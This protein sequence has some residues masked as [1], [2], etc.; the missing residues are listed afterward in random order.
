MGDFVWE[1]GTDA[2]TVSDGMARI[3]GVPAGEPLP[4]V[5]YFM[6][7]AGDERSEV[8]RR[9]RRAV[10]A[11]RPID[12]DV[13][14][15]RPDG[16]RVT[17]NVRGEVV[18]DADGRPERVTGTVQDVTARRAAE[19]AM[20]AK[21]QAERANR[22]KSEFLSRMSHELRTPLN[23]ILGFGQLLE[24]DELGPD[25]EDSVAHIMRAGHH[26]LELID[27][28]LDLSRIEAGALRLMLEPVDVGSVVEEILG[29]AAP[30]AT[31]EAIELTADVPHDLHVRADR[32]RLRQVLLNLVSNAIKYNR[33]A[34]RVRVSV[35]AHGELGRIAVED[36]GLGIAADD[37][38]KLF[39]PFERLGAEAS[40]VRGTGL[41]LAVSR[42][43]CDGMGGVLAA[44][45]TVGEG[46]TFAVDL[47]LAS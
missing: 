19:A 34:G 47:P 21:E 37:L 12:R 38:P 20:Q 1:A 4:L 36:T 45:S 9:L 41:G 11:G 16:T 14:M 10:A 25:S 42:S 15:I 26:L 31:E 43:L 17:V 6:R 3:V 46:S 28:V 30:L 5:A 27:E 7:V 2:I 39:S 44:V 23:A 29:L 8:E 22:A 24:L 33:P 40:H 13:P 35:R 18:L 32:Q